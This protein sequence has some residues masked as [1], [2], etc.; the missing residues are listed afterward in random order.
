ML[1]LHPELKLLDAWTVHPHL[2]LLEHLAPVHRLRVLEPV[3]EL[4]SL[5]AADTGGGSARALPRGRACPARKPLEF[6]GAVSGAQN[7]GG[8][9]ESEE[10]E[11]GNYMEGG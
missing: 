1:Q 4:R 10:E 5:P 3:Q 11:R 8:R 2:R 9:V 7:L 6:L